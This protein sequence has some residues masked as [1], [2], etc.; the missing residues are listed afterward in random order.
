MVGHASVADCQHVLGFNFVPLVLVP[1]DYERSHLS[2]QHG[3]LC[4]VHN[5]TVTLHAEYFARREVI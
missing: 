5:M 1:T 3:E 4:N 2:L